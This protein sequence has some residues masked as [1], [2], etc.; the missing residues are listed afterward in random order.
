MII[1]DDSTSRQNA[2]DEDDKESEPRSDWNYAK[3]P[4]IRL[5]TRNIVQP[6]T[7]NKL[8]DD[9]TESQADNINFRNAITHTLVSGSFKAIAS[10]KNFGK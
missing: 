4:T 10:Q 8:Y 2:Q 1:K 6:S 3:R 7:P 5:S 9:E